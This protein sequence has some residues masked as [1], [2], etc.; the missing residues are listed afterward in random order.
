MAFI[1]EIIVVTVVKYT[2]CYESPTD[3]REKRIV[4]S[5]LNTH[6]TRQY[7][8]YAIKVYKRHGCKLPRILDSGEWSDLE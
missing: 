4:H 2:V 7:V 1:Y 3:I 8:Y 5:S 6:Q